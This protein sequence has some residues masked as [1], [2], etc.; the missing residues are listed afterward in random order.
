MKGFSANT[1][2]QMFLNKL[3]REAEICSFINIHIYDKGSCA[4]YNNFKSF[5]IF[6]LMYGEARKWLPLF[7]SHMTNKISLILLCFFVSTL[8][9]KCLLNKNKHQD[10]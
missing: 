5:I 4:A 8:T 2:V 6:S 10:C 9:H 7:G 1:K 3:V